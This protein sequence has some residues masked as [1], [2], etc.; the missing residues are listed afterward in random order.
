M[1]TVYMFSQMI[2]CSLYICIY[3]YLLYPLFIIIS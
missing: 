2:E 1:K 3:W